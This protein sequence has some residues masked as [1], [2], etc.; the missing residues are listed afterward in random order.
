MS[1][2]RILICIR[3]RILEFKFQEGN[4][5]ISV[6]NGTYMA[7]IFLDARI[8]VYFAWGWHGFAKFF[9]VL[10]AFSLL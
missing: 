10:N 3:H 2:A 9:L 6:V 7:R 1:C 8:I 5:G 4:V